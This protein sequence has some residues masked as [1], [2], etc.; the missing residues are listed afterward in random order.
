MNHITPKLTDW[1]L[2]SPETIALETEQFAWAEQIAQ[3]MVGEAAQW[4]TYMQG[5]ACSGFMDWLTHRDPNITVD[6]QRCSLHN[7]AIAS[8]LGSVCHLQVG[9]FRLALLGV[10]N[11]FAEEIWVPKAVIDLPEF[12][13]HFYVVLEVQEEWGQVLVR[14]YERY[15]TLAQQCH[16][17]TAE[18][19]ADLEAESW[20]YILPLTIFDEE[21]NHLLL[22]LQWLDPTAM[23]LPQVAT[24]RDVIE[25]NCWGAIQTWLRSP[26]DNLFDHLSWP[27][28]RAILQ[29]SRLLHQLYRWRQQCQLPLFQSPQFQADQTLDISLHQSP[30]Q[31]S[32][33]ARIEQSWETILARLSTLFQSLSQP[34][35]NVT[36]W[37]RGE[38]DRTA[39]AAGIFLPQ[40]TPITSGLR[41]IDKFQAAIAELKRQGMA[42]PASA[43]YAYQDI[44]LRGV[45]VR[46]CT[47]HWVSSQT[48]SPEARE[49]REAGSNPEAVDWS[50]LA[51]LGMQMGTALPNG[52]RME[53]RTPDR[54][55]AAPVSEFD[56]PFLYAKVEGSLDAPLIISLTPLDGPNWV[57][58]PFVYHAGRD[59]NNESSQSTDLG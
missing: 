16:A 57:S 2:T 29:N 58:L 19:E 27:Q 46:L 13:A 54:D 21:P 40:L 20:H 5:L 45:S 35:I 31:P 56:D 59:E 38:V 12:A 15:A 9:P 41:S 39:A 1:R 25:A 44:D 8:V 43:V 42:I 17:P 14:G 53:I 11:L 24:H 22:Q 7:P 6:A 28:G 23:P 49:P 3:A 18:S 4:Q 34:A 26:E 37:L 52:I 48:N 47:V 55:L 10:E 51:L 30:H 32:A 50:L 36:T 33:S